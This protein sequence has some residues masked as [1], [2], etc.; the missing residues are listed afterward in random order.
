MGVATQQAIVPSTQVAREVKKHLMSLPY[1]G[2]FDLITYSVDAD[3]VVTL[4]GYV[5]LGLIKADAEREAR[6]VKGVPE[7]HDKIEVAQ[8]YPLDDEIRHRVFHAIDGDPALSRYGT[9][10]S[11]LWSMRPAFRAWGQGFG[12]RDRELVN[13]PFFGLEPLGNYAI[14]IL[15]KARAVTLVGVVDNAG[16]KTIAEFKARSVADVS[17]VNNDLEVATKSSETK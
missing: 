1:Y 5:V 9:P 17:V 7:V 14:H 4:G 13:E 10:G 11:E 2:P 16:D 12:M 8:A 6:E 15:V 3:N